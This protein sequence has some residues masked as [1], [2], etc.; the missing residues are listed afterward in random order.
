MSSSDF[1][2]IGG[3]ALD[4]ALKQL[5]PKF[6]KRIAKG[7]IRAGARVIAKQAKANAPKESGAL[8][9]S[10]QV[11]TRKTKGADVA[12]VTRHKKKD[13]KQGKGTAYAHIIEF[14][15]KYIPARPFLRP[16]LDSK[17]KEAV[18]AVGKYV[19]ERIAKLAA[20]VR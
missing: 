18:K 12:V 4:K 14:G 3:K 9:R 13:I 17:A 16:A 7:A 19:Q 8:K 15:S 11:V 20:E 6:E 5:G 10:I 2:I 1:K